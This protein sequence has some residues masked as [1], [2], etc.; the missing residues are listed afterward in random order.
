M[1]MILIAASL[2]LPQHVNFILHRAW[3]YWHGDD[4]GLGDASTEVAKDMIKN[5][6]TMLAD[7]AKET[8]QLASKNSE[9]LRE[10]VGVATSGRVEL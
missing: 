10:A 4:N 9:A 7:M 6:S 1:S 2:Y 3:F 8:M 5:T